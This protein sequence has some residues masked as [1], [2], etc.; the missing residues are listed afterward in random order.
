MPYCMPIR[1]SSRRRRRHDVPPPLKPLE[2]GMDRLTSLTAFV[3][4]AESRSFTAAGRKLGISSSA[5]GK[6][7]VRLEE[8]LGVRLFHRSPR[9]I[10]LTTEG[11][12]FLKR[13]QRIFEEV[14]AA[15][16]E[17]A[18]STATPRGRLK[19]SMPFA[20]MLL[21]PPLSSFASQYPDIELD[22]D[23]SDRMVDVIEEGSDVVM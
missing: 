10:T 16:L 3:Q 11:A 22:L 18:Q 5:V 7:I 6:T 8:R 15:E 14:E 2:P 9:S 23:F 12:A 1:R 20:G 4:A 13:C 19:V 21:T 17:M